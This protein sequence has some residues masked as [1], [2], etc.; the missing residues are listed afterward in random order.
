MNTS[1]YLSYIERK[2]FV[3]WNIRLD[4]EKRSGVFQ[5][6]RQTQFLIIP[7]LSSA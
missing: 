6:L 4:N 5:P 1:R 2:N 7:N 3:Y